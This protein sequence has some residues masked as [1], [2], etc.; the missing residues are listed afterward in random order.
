MI[1]L[2]GSVYARQPPRRDDVSGPGHERFVPLRQLPEWPGAP[3]V[4][5]PQ[6]IRRRDGQSAPSR[7][8][9]SAAGSASF[10]AIRIT[11]PADPAGDMR[12][13]AIPAA[14]WRAE[15]LRRGV[16][17]VW[18]TTRNGRPAKTRRRSQGETRFKVPRTNQS[19][20]ARRGGHRHR[21]EE[22]RGHATESR[23]ASG[24]RSIRPG[25]CRPRRPACRSQVRDQASSF[26]RE[27]R[28][29]IMPNERWF[30]GPH[31]IG[32]GVEPRPVVGLA[33]GHVGGG[34]G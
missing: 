16:G 2:T 30:Y 6:P 17:S 22:R 25:N 13:S 12:L 7:R 20:S 4:R 23:A 1:L 14:F 21:Q 9:G 29:L 18:A 33:E 26:V 27:K 3:K 11:R 24:G 8:P 5:C 15:P 32:P 19:L 10:R 31:M 34:R 28:I